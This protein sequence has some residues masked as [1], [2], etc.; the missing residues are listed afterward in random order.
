MG[1]KS[2]EFTQKLTAAMTKASTDV[3][4]CSN[5]LALIG[6]NRHDM[7]QALEKIEAKMKLQPTKTFEELAKTDAELKKLGEK[8]ENAEKELETNKAKL[9]A[10]VTLAQT[11]VNSAQDVITKFLAFCTEKAKTWNPLKKKSLAK[12]LAALSKANVDL[13]NLKKF[14][15]GV[16]DLQKQ[17]G[18]L[19]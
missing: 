10:T 4:R 19:A 3:G 11:S 9:K 15:D 13:A 1:Q 18:N 8:F 6:Y 7:D 12:S 5:G 17:K 16:A 14:L 2:N